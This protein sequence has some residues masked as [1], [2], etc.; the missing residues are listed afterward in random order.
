[1]RGV[2]L[3]SEGYKA[4]RQQKRPDKAKYPA[5]IYSLY[6]GRRAVMSHLSSNYIA[7]FFDF[8]LSIVLPQGKGNKATLLFLVPQQNRYNLRNN[9]LHAL[10]GN[11]YC[12]V[13]Y[14]KPF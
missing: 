13:R 5:K 3:F 6:A 8:F 10:L 2:N 4:V 12:L 1:M 9:A 14:S 11:G 7:R